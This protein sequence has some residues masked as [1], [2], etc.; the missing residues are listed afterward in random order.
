MTKEVDVT[1]SNKECGVSFDV[2]SFL[3]CEDKRDSIAESVQTIQNCFH[4]ITGLSDRIQ[5]ELTQIALQHADDNVR[6]LAQSVCNK[7]KKLVDEFEWSLHESGPDWEDYSLASLAE[8]F[9]DKNGDGWSETLLIPLL[10]KQFKSVVEKDFTEELFQ[11]HL[12][13]IRKQFH[14]SAD[15]R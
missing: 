12:A 2:L 9:I 6:E 5:S 1:I 7:F 15:F 13:H 11:G 4:L 14:L 8:Y 10:R 3:E